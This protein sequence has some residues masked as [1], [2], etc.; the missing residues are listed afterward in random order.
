MLAQNNNGILA[1]TVYGLIAATIWAGFPAL[2]QFSIEQTLTPYDITALRFG[3]AGVLLLPFYFR[4]GLGGIRW[5]VALL[6]TFGAGAPYVL[7][8]AAGLWYAPAAH[9]GVITPSCMLLFS[10][11][12]SRLLLGDRLTRA[13]LVGIGVIVCGLVALGWE[14]LASFGGATW[15]GDLMFAAG[16]LMWATYTV[17]SRRFKLDPFHATVLVAV[18]S[19]VAFIPLYGATFGSVLLQ[20][21]LREILVQGI[22][23]GILSAIVA[24]LCFTRAVAILGA[25]R[26]AVFGALVP[27][28]ALLFAIPILGQFPTRLQITGVAF[29]TVGMLFALGLFARRARDAAPL[30]A[31]ID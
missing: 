8:T 12:G 20:A 24:L 14:G 31:R 7:M 2:T 21:P 23:Q 18:F 27:G 19:L 9:F 17:S 22:F 25:A 3:I 11:L 16:G 15:I 28:L 13:R 5:P 6:I 29:V 4:R 10:A 26:G 30:I 1:G